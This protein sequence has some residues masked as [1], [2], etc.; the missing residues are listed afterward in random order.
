L[1]LIII[2]VIV[3]ILVVLAITLIPLALFPGDFDSDVLG[4]TQGI[5]TIQQLSNL[6][7]STLRL[8]I[9]FS[10]NT[11]ATVANQSITEDQGNAIVTAVNTIL[12]AEDLEDLE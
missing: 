11:N 9:A 10:N 12:Q 4:Q 7:D 3:A 6:N 2:Y 5:I 8:D 1:R